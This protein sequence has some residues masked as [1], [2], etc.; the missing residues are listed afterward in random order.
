MWT[1]AVCSSGWRAML[2]CAGRWCSGALVPRQHV[3][4]REREYHHARRKCHRRIGTKMR[5][6][7]LLLPGPGEVSCTDKNGWNMVSSTHFRWAWSVV[8]VMVHE[9]KG[10]MP[11]PT[12]PCTTVQLYTVLYTRHK[13]AYRCTVSRSF[14]LCAVTSSL[15]GFCKIQCVCSMHW[16]A[17]VKGPISWMYGCTDSGLLRSTPYDHVRFTGS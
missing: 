5:F 14:V 13:C 2:T 1:R 10:R 15:V 3:A 4:H 8:C 7:A 6:A 16:P 9:V 17:F 11:V 12:K